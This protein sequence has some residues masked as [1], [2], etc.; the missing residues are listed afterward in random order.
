MRF[1]FAQAPSQRHTPVAE[2][3]EPIFV[4]CSKKGCLGGS[5]DLLSAYA[6]AEGLVFNAT[7]YHCEFGYEQGSP[8]C[9]VCDRSLGYGKNGKNTCEKCT[10]SEAFCK[11]ERR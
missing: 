3:T 8:L 7:G 9:S 6:P 5:Y 10:H 1:T 11:P 4:K 2:V